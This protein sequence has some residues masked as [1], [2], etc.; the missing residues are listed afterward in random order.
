[1]QLQVQGEAST[2]DPKIARRRAIL[3][4]VE[5]GELPIDEAERLLI[6]LGSAENPSSED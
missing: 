3:E 5:R 6:N 1:M 2:P 4:A